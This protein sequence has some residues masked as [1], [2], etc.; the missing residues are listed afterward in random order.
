VLPGS[1]PRFIAGRAGGVDTL[2]WAGRGVDGGDET[3]TAAG[4][5]ISSAHADSMTATAKPSDN[6]EID[7]VFKLAYSS[8]YV[9]GALTSAKMRCLGMLLT[10]A[11]V[12]D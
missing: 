3:A 10:S 11:R 12:I 4:F 6:C 9:N 5:G 1:S 2:D 8:A 7:G